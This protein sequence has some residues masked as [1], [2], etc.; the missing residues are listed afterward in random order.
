MWGTHIQ[1]FALKTEIYCQADFEFCTFLLFIYFP[2][3]C[4][5][6]SFLN[7]I[8]SWLTQFNSFIVGRLCKLAVFGQNKYIF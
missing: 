7:P 1:E 6:L 4:Q 3:I 5:K 2:H 8:L